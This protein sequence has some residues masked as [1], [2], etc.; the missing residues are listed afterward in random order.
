LGRFN[1]VIVV[2]LTVS[3]LALFVLSLTSWVLGNRRERL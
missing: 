2:I 1:I 3:V